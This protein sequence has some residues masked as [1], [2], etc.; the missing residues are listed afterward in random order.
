ML[1]SHPK[2]AADQE[3]FWPTVRNPIKILENSYKKVVQ[4]GQR[5]V[6]KD[7]MIMK[8][9]YLKKLET[10]LENDFYFIL[11][12]RNPYDSLISYA[13]TKTDYNFIIYSKLFIE[14]YKWLKENK[15]H[16]ERYLE[17]R[18]ESLVKHPED[19]LNKICKFTQ[20]SF[21]LSMLEHHKFS[22]SKKNIII[23]HHSDQQ[24]AKSVFCRIGQSIRQILERNKF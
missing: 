9:D 4:P 13:K 18:Y 3:L 2:L 6:I 22:E 12:K 24:A 5:F 1:D 10:L 23:D 7:A 16:S 20:V 17:I 14:A 19:T 15:W 11:I 8:I 21:N